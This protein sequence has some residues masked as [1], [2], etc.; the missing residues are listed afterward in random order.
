MTISH[1]RLM[2]EL[3]RA[4]TDAFRL[5][6]PENSRDPE[7]LRELREMDNPLMTK[8]RGLTE[9]GARIVAELLA[10]FEEQT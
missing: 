5:G 6:V 8:G 1:A 3:L 10:T 2:S 4:Y 7:A 9:E